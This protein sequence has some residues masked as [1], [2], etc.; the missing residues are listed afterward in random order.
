MDDDDSVDDH[1]DAWSS[2]LASLPGLLPFSRCPP[3][4]VRPDASGSSKVSISSLDRFERSTSSV[5]SP[6]AGATTGATHTHVRSNPMRIFFSV[7]SHRLSAPRAQNPLPMKLTDR[8]LLSV[9]GF[10]L[11]FIL[12]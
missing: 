3:N 9:R 5:S 11:L 12:C 1:D 10:L 7:P 2:I 6:E 4:Q 8:D